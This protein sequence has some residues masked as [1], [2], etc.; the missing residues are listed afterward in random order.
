MDETEQIAA[1]RAENDRLRRL[2]AQH[3]IAP[4][5]PKVASDQPAPIGPISRNGELSTDEKV[6][7]FRRLFRG[8]DDVYALRWESSTSGRSGYAPA[9][10]N[11]WR[12]G[13]CRKPTIKCG[14]C[15]HRLLLPLDEQAIFKHLSGEAVL[16]VYPLL[17]GDQCHFLAVD[18]DRGD[19][20]G[21]GAAF[22]ATCAEHGV[23]AWC[24]ISRSGK[25]AHVWIF[26][27]EAIPA[28]E[29]RQL[30]TAL[31]S[32][33]CEQ[34]RQLELASYDRLL[35]NQDTLP[36]GGFGNLIALPLQKQ[37][38]LL[39]HSVFVDDQ[40]RPWADQWAG[41]AAVTPTSRSQVIDAISRLCQGR[42][43]L[44][45]FQLEDD[46][47]PWERS[48]AGSG[49]VPGPL[50]EQL[51]V[52]LANQLYVAKE[53]IPQPLMNR[54]I[55][56]AAF[57]NPEFFKAQKMR[58]PVWGKPRVIGCAEELGQYL[59]LPRG[60]LE[61]LQAFLSDQGVDLDIQDER[62]EGSRLKVRFT[63]TLRSEQ[64]TALKAILRHDCGVLCAPTA[65]GKTVTAAALIA[66]RRTSTLIL[67]HRTELMRQWQERLGSFLDLETIGL[68]GGGKNRPSGKVDVA[69]LQSL[70][71]REDFGF[72]DDYGQIIVDE[73]H[74]LSAFS[75]ESLL[76]R[77]KAKF[78]I[79]L[80]ATPERRDGHHP[81]IFMQCGPIRHRAKQP[82]SG[83]VDLSVHPT[84]LDT[85]QRDE[86][87]IQAIFKALVEHEERNALIVADTIKAWEDGRKVLVLSERTEHLLTLH[88]RLSTAVDQCFLLHGRLSAKQR[89]ETLEALDAL[90][91]ETPRVLIASGRLIGEGFDHPP[92]DTLVLAMPVSWKGTL[93][94]YAGRLHRTVAS[95][96]D[97]K[98]FDYVDEHQPQL[99]R[100]WEKRRRGYEAMGYR[101]VEGQKQLL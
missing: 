13:V 1:L 91:E 100:M 28:S 33:T 67:V 35:P 57:Q 49:K 20:R 43:A 55:R 18:F 97:V 69:V 75:F 80:T 99:S 2:L 76:K 4:D 96:E 10:A 58:L 92:L 72:L 48:A 45:V 31:I 71:R 82:K 83:A 66:R 54:L 41:L 27:D 77:S 52:V 9:C 22:A 38:R 81:I 65:F 12:A 26:F 85:P 64:K 17:S 79:G 56:L 3:G 50:P 84:W 25:G 42:P 60:C 29:A 87:S 30:G 14:A 6:A 101:I 8:R 44:D 19:W 95:K 36:R 47:K 15:N 11:E 74:H 51:T 34:T 89:R 68:I 93:Q 63:G 46:G 40:W 7:L 23:A 86:E 78:V 73:C 32:K 5:P 61:P 16:G 39:G 37:A 62:V 59:A 24:E 90:D 94:Q 88:E 70:S 98:I 21:D 53:A